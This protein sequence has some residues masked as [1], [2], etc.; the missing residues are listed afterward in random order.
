MRLSV[1]LTILF[2]AFASVALGVPQGPLTN[3]ERMRLGLPLL[4]PRRMYDAG[5]AVARDST[6]SGS[7]TTCSSGTTQLCCDSI[8]SSSS[9]EARAL[10]ALLGI[11]LTD[12]VDVGIDC[13]SISLLSI[14]GSSCSAQTVCC[15]NNN[16]S[17]L[18]AL[19]C[20]PINVNL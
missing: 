8:E 10:L 11:V 16:Y 18:I 12:V 7:P 19:G 3:A 2:V 15:E 9:A 17:G 20:S 14:L 6:P 5:K 1:F 13:S 4:K